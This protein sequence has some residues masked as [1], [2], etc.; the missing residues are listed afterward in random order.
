VKKFKKVNSSTKVD[1]TEF[2]M[3]NVTEREESEFETG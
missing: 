3:K 1:E 2:L